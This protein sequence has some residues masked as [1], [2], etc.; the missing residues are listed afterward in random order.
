MTR[1]KKMA[2]LISVLILN[3]L[4]LYTFVNVKANTASN[5]ALDVAINGGILNEKRGEPSYDYIIG[6]DHLP[7]FR[8]FF[9]VDK[10]ATNYFPY[11]DNDIDTDV[12]KHGPVDKWFV[13]E[14]SE[15]K[16]NEKL[17]FIYVPKTFVILQGEGFQNKI[18]LE[19]N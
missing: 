1:N 15:V 17:V 8:V 16:G 19:Y 9:W 6:N 5:E 13:G 11:A 12:S 4:C 18:H 3:T 2:F 10:S 14:T 7:H